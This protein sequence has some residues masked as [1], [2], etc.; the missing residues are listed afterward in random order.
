MIRCPAAHRFN[1]PIESLTC[2]RQDRH[3]P[4]TT[5]VTSH[6]GR[7]SRQR[8]HDGRDS[9]GGS[10]IRAFPAG[11]RP[12]TGQLA[13]VRGAGAGVARLRG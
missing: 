1:G 10:A 11:P 9:G 6:A 8:T 2:E 12:E 4:D 13:G 3:A 5:G 7:D